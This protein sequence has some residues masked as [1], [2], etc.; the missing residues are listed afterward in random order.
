MLTQSRHIRHISQYHSPNS[1]RIKKHLRIKNIDAG[2]MSVL[3][4]TTIESGCDEIIAVIFKE[5]SK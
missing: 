3:K 2:K 1:K 4:S 5:K